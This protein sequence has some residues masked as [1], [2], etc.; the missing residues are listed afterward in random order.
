MFG[1]L[2]PAMKSDF[3]E[4]P[5]TVDAT[6]YVTELHYMLCYRDAVHLWCAWSTEF[7]LAVDC[8]P[9]GH[10]CTLLL[11]LFCYFLV[12]DAH[13][14]FEQMD[15]SFFFQLHLTYF[16]LLFYLDEKYLGDNKPSFFYQLKKNK[17]NIEQLIKFQL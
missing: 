5:T 14:H 13:E 4:M 11:V 16:T 17:I 15:T 6:T 12:T 10:R 7:W 9:K 8:G 3:D 1:A 2:C